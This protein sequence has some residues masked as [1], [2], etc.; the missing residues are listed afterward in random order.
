ML[1]HF[2]GA[3]EPPAPL[4]VLILLGFKAIGARYGARNIHASG[5]ELEFLREIVRLRYS[6]S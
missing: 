3:I 1:R 2:G 6:E 5:S 4:N